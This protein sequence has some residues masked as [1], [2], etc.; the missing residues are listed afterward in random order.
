MSN[1]KDIRLPAMNIPFPK[2]PRDFP[3]SPRENV[4]RAFDHKKPLWMPDFEAGSQL[5]PAGPNEDQI[6][7]HT[8]GYTDWFGVE[9]HYSEAQSSATPAGNVLSEVTK[10]KDE[11][12]WPDVNKIDWTAGSEGFVRDGNLAVYGWFIASCFER[13]HTLEGFEQALIDLI[14]EPKICREFF[15]ASMD[16]RIDVF[17]RMNDVY[18][19]DY[20]V[21]NDDWGTERGPFFSVDLFKETIL[22]PVARAIKTIKQSGVKVMFHNCGLIDSFIPYL[23]DDIGSD[24]LQ[25]QNINNFEHILK[26]YGDRCTPEYR[27]PEPY[28][29]FDPD[30]AE[31]QI[32]ELARWM[33]DTYGAHVNPG[34]GC[35]CTVYAP[36]AE[37][38]KAFDDEMYSYSL[39]K[40]K[41]LSRI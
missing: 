4:M 21:F 39:D 10:W 22:P 15:E 9:Y 29:L 32:K 38:Y 19:Y 12:V 2:I 34:S 6:S 37:V 31:S 41:G 30:T 35:A 11:V 25:I 26:T 23:V 40:Y 18:H 5:A 8:A 1:I 3:I 24:A 7:K 27:R 16:F 17:N 20:I 14:T 36:T 33:V 13:L 28:L